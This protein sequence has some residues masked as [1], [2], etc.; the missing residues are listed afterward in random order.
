MGG[1][2]DTD[3]DHIQIQKD[4][5][6]INEYVNGSLTVR[7]MVFFDIDV[8]ARKYRDRGGHGYFRVGEDLQE[9]VRK[10]DAM[11]IEREYV[12]RCLMTVCLLKE[13]DAYQVMMKA[14]A[15]GVAVV[16]TYLFETAETYCARLKAKGL[17]ANII[18]V[19]NAD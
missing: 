6:C 3:G 15:D 9:L 1:F 18:P 12:A 17:S 11:F 5:I 16:G 13:A 14:H 10:R 4:G 2:T 7:N 8:R 19:D